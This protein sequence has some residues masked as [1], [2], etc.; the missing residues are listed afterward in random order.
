[1]AAWRR[2]AGRE[3]VAQRPP[4]LKGWVAVTIRAGLSGSDGDIRQCEKALIDLLVEHR[5]V[6]SDGEIASISV[7]WDRSIPI[8]RVH[9]EVRSSTAPEERIGR[10]TRDKI[11]ANNTRVG[12]D[13]IPF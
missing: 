2:L 13:E 11:A 12:A 7:R 9:L 6:G 3:L 8:G 1:M 4:A 10:A 5:V